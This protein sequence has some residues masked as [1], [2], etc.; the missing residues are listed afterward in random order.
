MKVTDRTVKALAYARE[1]AQMLRLGYRHH[2]D[3]KINRGADRGKKVVD[4]RIS[5][6]GERIYYLVK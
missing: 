5:C 1:Y 2:D 6:D 3:W 4:V